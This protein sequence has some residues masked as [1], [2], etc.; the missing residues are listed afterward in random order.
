VEIAGLAARHG[1]PVVLSTLFETGVGV[2]AALHVAAALEQLAAGAP[3]PL[4]DLDHGLATAGLL[5]HDL[6]QVG[7]VVEHGRMWLPE[8]GAAGVTGGLGIALDEAAVRRYAVASIGA[9]A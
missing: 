2:A 8:P 1:I 5:E 9:A 7:L 6:L 3:S 4:A